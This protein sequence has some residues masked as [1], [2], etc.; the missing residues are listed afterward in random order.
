MS[1]SLRQDTSDK[2]ASSLKPESQKSTLESANDSLKSAADSA[3]SY[4]QPQG[5]KSTTQK[6]T[7]AVS[8]DNTNT[9]KTQQGEGLL[10]QAQEAIGNAAQQASHA[11]GLDQ[12]K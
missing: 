7:D 9:S 2:V 1:D 5:E 12:K 8:G 6:A 4:V 11:L 10:A 3:A